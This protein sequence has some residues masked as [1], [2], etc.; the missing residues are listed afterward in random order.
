M[1]GK[2]NTDLSSVLPMNARCARIAAEGGLVASLRQSPPEKNEA[3]CGDHAA[4]TEPDVLDFVAP[5]AADSRA[6]SSLS[7]PGGR[8]VSSSLSS[9]D[10]P[11]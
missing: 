11:T 1:T 5:Q 8:S 7:V 4:G 3:Q 10:E 2:M 6:A 9:D